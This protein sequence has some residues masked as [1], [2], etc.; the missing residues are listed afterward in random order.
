MLRRLRPFLLSTR[1][2]RTTAAALENLYDTLGVPTNATTKQIKAAYFD[3]AKKCHPDVNND[4][5]SKAVFQDISKAYQVL[6]NDK[7]RAEYNETLDTEEFVYKSDVFRDESPEAVFKTAFGMNFE[8]MFDS[9]FGYSAEEDNVREYALGISLKEAALGSAKYIEINT[10]QRCNNCQGYGCAEGAPK[11]RVQ[12]WRCFGGGQV[13]AEDVDVSWMGLENKKM[14]ELKG[15]GDCGGR[16]YIISKPCDVCGGI[17]RRDI[18]Q[19]HPISVPAGVKHCQVLNC[20]GI[21]G[22]P[23]LITIHIMPQADLLFDYDEDGSIHSNIQVHYSTLIQGGHVTV[24]TID[25]GQHR[26]F[27]EPYTQPGTKVQLHDVTPAHAYSVLLFLPN[28]DCVTSHMDR[29]YKA[30][31]EEEQEETSS[32]HAP[33]NVNYCRTLDLNSLT[34]FQLFQNDLYFYAVAPVRRLLFWPVSGLYGW[35]RTT[36]RLGGFI[37]L[38]ESSKGHTSHYP[39]N[40][41][42]VAGPC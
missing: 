29:T 12:C 24:D 18:I 27:I 21:D 26:L 37:K 1:Y 7:T 41:K 8:A 38:I 25:G 23:M 30:L 34:K 35:A 14:P 2:F 32:K 17:G 36:K 22:S 33:L 10:H 5:Q 40:R 20:P 28:P 31:L 42:D 3:L 9:R 16:G 6:S 4:T 19:W 11:S 39:R 13:P 15:C